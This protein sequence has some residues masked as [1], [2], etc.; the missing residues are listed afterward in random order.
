MISSGNVSSESS[1]VTSGAAPGGGGRR[2]PRHRD[3][4]FLQPCCRQPHHRRQPG[5]RR[6][7]RC[8][9]LAHRLSPRPSLRAPTTA[10][11][12]PWTGRTSRLP[13]RRRPTYNAPSSLRQ[14]R[15]H[16]NGALTA[17]GQFKAATCAHDRGSGERHLIP[18]NRWDCRDCTRFFRAHPT[19]VATGAD[20]IVTVD[21]VANDLNNF[22]PKQPGQ[23]ERGETG[24]R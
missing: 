15:P 2:G 1:Q 12:T 6:G 14:C 3:A 8:L 21:G 5:P 13:S 19:S 11:A 20:G 7:R 22:S 24:P 9:R 17:S 16:P 23:P 18:G 10:L 4:R